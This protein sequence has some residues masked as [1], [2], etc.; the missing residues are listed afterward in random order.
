MEGAT[1]MRYNSHTETFYVVEIYQSEIEILNFSG[2]LRPIVEV[3][4]SPAYGASPLMVDFNTAGTYDPDGDPLSY[5]WYFGDGTSSDLPN[6]GHLFEAPDDQPFS[7]TVDLFV[8]DTA[9]N[10]VHRQILVS[11][12]NTPPQVDITSIED[13]ELYRMEVPTYFTLEADVYDAEQS[14]LDLQYSWEV[15]LHHNFHFHGVKE[16][17]TAT[18]DFL[19]N[20]VGC[21]DLNVYYFSVSLQVTDPEG[22]I[23]YDEVNLYPD[24][25]G[26]LP[27]ILAFEESVLYPNPN[28]G[29]F[30]LGFDP[31]KWQ[32]KTIDISVFD[33][34]GKRI[35]LETVI[36]DAYM[37]K[38]DFN[39]N[40]LPS[41]MY[42]ILAEGPDFKESHKL[43]IS[44]D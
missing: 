13:D 9:D 44:K 21:E 43:M 32:E 31:E 7:F 18:S 8:S 35:L 30:S 1:E 36:T 24:C 11:L 15:N 3:S 10:M 41:G 42:T 28:Q 38:I 40:S 22:L 17:N 5:E 29:I 2:N 6:P 23:G 37:R 39:L 26:I 33:L 16:E 12:N 27:A 34:Q 14:S 19:L 25:N 4:P 20:P